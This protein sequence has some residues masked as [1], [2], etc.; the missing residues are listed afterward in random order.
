MNPREQ[1]GAY[2]LNGITLNNKT[3]NGIYSLAMK[4][5]ASTVGANGREDPNSLLIADK[6]EAIKMHKTGDV[7][8]QNNVTMN[9]N[10]DELSIASNLQRSMNFRRRASKEMR[11]NSAKWNNSGKGK[12]YGTTISHKSPPA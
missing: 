1:S 8:K 10:R 12:N 11:S 7:G 5:A 6:E 9:S 2:E 3:S 4:S